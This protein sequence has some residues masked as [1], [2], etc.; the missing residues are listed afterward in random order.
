MFE[1]VKIEQ[2]V[3]K[4]LWERYCA[5]SYELARNNKANHDPNERELFH[6]SHDLDLIIRGTNAA[7]LDPRLK[8]EGGCEYGNGVYYAA[9]AAYCAAYLQGWLFRN[10]DPPAGEVQVLLALV[11]LG[12]CK[13]F[14]PLCTS[15]RG[16]NFARDRG[17]APRLKDFWKEGKH[18]NR[19][20]PK[21]MAD[22]NSALYD[23]VCGTEGNITW[24]PNPML[25][26]DGER[27]GQQFVVFEAA[28]SYPYLRITLKYSGVQ[29]GGG[30]VGGEGART[31]ETE[32][33]RKERAAEQRKSDLQKEKTVPP[34]SPP[35]V[36]PAASVQVEGPASSA[37]SSQA[38]RKSKTC[39][40]S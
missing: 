34:A 1:V 35:R 15:Q 20:P 8:K 13:D 40:V 27:L 32:E 24:S 5:K 21:D 7:G 38:S 4:Y 19:G 10:E 22:K 26:G 16:N 9:H 11:S 28:Q 14:G 23:S 30:V 25:E 3:N 18:R 36:A 2:V 6:V 12:D 33:E 17:V 29:D 37:G 31:T 39:A